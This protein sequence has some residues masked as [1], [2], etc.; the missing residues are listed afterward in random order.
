MGI[1]EIFKSQ[2]KENPVDFSLKWLEVD[3]HS[4]LIPGIDDGV[5]TLSESI[6]LIKRMQEY[7]LRKIITTPHI[8]TEYFRNTPEIIRL[9]L[10]EV[11]LAL[12]KEGMDIQ[13]DA[14]AE[15]YLDEVF[16]EKVE[17]GQ[18]LLTIKDNLVLVETGFMNKPQMMLEI[19]FAM[20]M[21][22]YKPILAHP[23]RYHYLIKDP[24]FLQDLLDREIY[25]QINLLSLTGFYSK[26]IKHFAEMLIDE[27]KVKLFG[28][29]CHNH[30]YLDMLETLPQSKYFEKIQDMD[31]LNRYL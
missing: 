8:M 25:F 23:E 4:H 20:E 27:N 2:K 31:I 30:R 12:Q 13:V 3:M 1:L 10:E 19:F 15:Y 28:T 5:K 11:R 16:L 24:Q 21:N 14:A 17:S 22:G 6:I 9:G 7:G 29:D 18:E 26:P